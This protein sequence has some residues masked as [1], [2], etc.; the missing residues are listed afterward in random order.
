VNR[1][2]GVEKYQ[3]LRGRAGVG[4]VS[5][6]PPASQGSELY[7]PAEQR[8]QGRVSM[9]VVEGGELHPGLL[10]G[11]SLPNCPGEKP[12]FGITF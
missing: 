10:N 12:L 6:I 4:R 8:S 7:T 11:T 5:C 2:V 1:L 3:Y 9:I